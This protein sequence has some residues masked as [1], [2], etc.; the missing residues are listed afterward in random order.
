[1]RRGDVN[2][3][4]LNPTQVAAHGSGGDPAEELHVEMT[5]RQLSGMLGKSPRSR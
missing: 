4:C 3:L 1:M 5:L 2:R